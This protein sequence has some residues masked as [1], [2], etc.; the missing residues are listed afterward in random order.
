MNTD[1]WQRQVKPFHPT[2]VG[3]EWDCHNP[4]AHL[5][6]TMTAFTGTGSGTIYDTYMGTNIVPDCNVILRFQKVYLNCALSDTKWGD[7]G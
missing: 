3:S 6:L 2:S 7:S 1:R 5:R 4:P